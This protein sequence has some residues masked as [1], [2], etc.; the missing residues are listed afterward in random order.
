MMI[1]ILIFVI[2]TCFDTNESKLTSVVRTKNGYVQGEI[3]RTISNS[4]EFSSFKGIPY[5]IPPLGYLRF[6]PPVPIKPW[7]G[8]LKATKEGP[9]CI[10]KDFVYTSEFTGSEDCLYLNV[11]TPEV[12]FSDADPRNLLPVMMWIYGGSFKRGYA[13]SFLYGPDFIIEEKVVLVTFNYRLGPLGFLNLKHDNATG[14]AALKD[15]NL[16]LRWINENIAQFGGDPNSVTLFGQ[17]AGGVAVDFHG[18]SEMSKGLFHRS[19]SMSASPLCPWAFHT[20]EAAVKQAFI[21]GEKLGKVASNKNELLKV[22]YESTATDIMTK[23]EDMG[24]SDPPFKPSIESTDVAINEKKFI[25]SCSYGNYVSGNFLRV[26]HL[27]GYTLNETLLFA[28]DVESVSDVAKFALQCAGS[29]PRSSLLPLP[30]TNQIFSKISNK[31]INIVDAFVSELID[32]TS[33]ILFVTGIDMKRKLM[34]TRNDQ[35]LFFYRFSYITDQ[36][37]HRLLYNISLNAHGDDFAYLFHMKILNFSLNSNDPTFITRKRMVRLWTN[38]AKYSNPTPRGSQDELLQR[39]TW[40]NSRINN[41]YLEFGKDLSV[42]TISMDKLV[43][44]LETG[45]PFAL[46]IQTGCTSDLIKLIFKQLNPFN[47]NNYVQ[48]SLNLGISQL[49]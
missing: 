39:I 3:L 35:P 41:F 1:A 7:N 47:K 19:I 43:E 17:S 29:F 37:L 11:Y 30:I 12:K 46:P 10:Q 16:V 24:S 33:D 38:F 9:N 34:S 2:F 13:N 15:Q 5:A 42:K 21:L 22:L 44:V 26:P 48:N 32:E 14:N 36:S 23:T 28:G 49:F 40:P 20:G 18:L 25:T 6:K 4:T 8:I 31:S 45:S 27:T